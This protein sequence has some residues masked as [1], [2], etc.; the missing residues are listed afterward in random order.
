[1]LVNF[2]MGLLNFTFTLKGEGFITIA[3]FVFSA[4]AIYGKKLTKDIDVM[5]VTGYNLF[6]GG[7]MLTLIGLVSG[8]RVNHF[9]AESSALLIYMAILSAASLFIMDLT[10]KI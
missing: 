8:G 6:I 5:V 7:V 3:A 4:S 2:S 1:M 10:S 9:T